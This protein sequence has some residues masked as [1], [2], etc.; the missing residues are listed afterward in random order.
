MSDRPSDEHGDA[1]DATNPHP[2]PVSA[3]AVFGDRL[4]MAEVYHRILATDGIEHGLLGPR[5]VP[6]LWDRHILNCA[7]IGD[8]IDDGESVVDIGSGAGLPGVALAIARPDLDVVLLE[9]LLRR[10]AFLERAV[11]ELG[12]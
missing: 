4:E 5:E 9:P 3:R 12:L 11:A 6:R 10:S 8:V 1:D 7:V 2:A